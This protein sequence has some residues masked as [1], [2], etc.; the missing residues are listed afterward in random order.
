MARERRNARVV[1]IDS[2]PP[3]YQGRVEMIRKWFVE[4]AVANDEAVASLVISIKGNGDI[5]ANGIGLDHDTMPLL[6]EELKR[7]HTK[8]ARAQAPKQSA[9]VHKLHC[10]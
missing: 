3:K 8:M 7:L 6:A 9:T 5:T 2:V 10:N 1:E 4:Q